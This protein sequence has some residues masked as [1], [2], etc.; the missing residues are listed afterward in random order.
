MSPELHDAL[1]D[2]VVRRLD[3]QLTG[4][5]L[6]EWAIHALEE[7]VET[8]SL[9]Y[10]AGLSPDSS[11]SQAG[12][13]FDRGL[14]GLKLKLPHSDDLRRAYVGA[15]S[16]ALLAGKLKPQE[17]LDRVHQRVVNPLGHPSDLTP[18]CFVWE[19]LD[20]TDYRRSRTR[21]SSSTPG[22]SPP[23]GPRSLR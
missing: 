21:R 15:V 23:R 10:L 22:G 20:P 8:E 1:V 5:P 3:I 11:I 6:V 19:G 16:R 17:A 18:W 14:A 12:P 13:L 4:A 2:L 9:I 7:G